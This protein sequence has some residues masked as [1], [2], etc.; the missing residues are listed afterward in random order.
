MRLEVRPAILYMVHTM[1]NR[2]TERIPQ[3]FLA[4]LLVLSS[5]SLS[6]QDIEGDAAKG[7]SLF[8]SNCA[9]CHKLDKK[10]VGPPLGDITEKRDREWLQKWIRNNQELR[11]AGDADAIAI[12][13]EYNGSVMTAFPALSDQ[14]IDD[15]L[16][17]TIE[18]N[19]KNCCYR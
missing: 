2:L 6:A 9:S 11:D 10:L 7:K 5:F 12:F 18:G 19:K 17:Y 3:T 4:I 14:D 15:I 13:E 16:Q 1:K 8:N